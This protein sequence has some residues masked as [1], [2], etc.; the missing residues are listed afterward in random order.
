MLEVMVF[1]LA[2]IGLLLALNLLALR[3]DDDCWYEYRDR[4]W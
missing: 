4:N 1:S 3:Q 2:V